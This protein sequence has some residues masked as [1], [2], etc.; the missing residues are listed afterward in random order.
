VQDGFR[1]PFDFGDGSPSI[2]GIHRNFLSHLAI[3]PEYLL[4]ATNHMVEGVHIVVVKNNLR[5]PI[6]LGIIGGPGNFYWCDGTRL[7]SDL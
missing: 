6:E 3:V 7:S 5:H 2:M 1:I 4:E